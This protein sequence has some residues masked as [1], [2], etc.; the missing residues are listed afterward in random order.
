M[1]T[2][3]FDNLKSSAEM[4]EIANE[5]ETKVA[6]AT[7]VT[8]EV[9]EEVKEEVKEEGDAEPKAEPDNKKP[10]GTPNH[11]PK[12]VLEKFSKM[13]AKVRNAEAR[14]TR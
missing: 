7:E 14:S 9:T 1:D 10:W 12:G 4:A 2:I 13:S 3:D 11:V 8:E 6:P 5:P